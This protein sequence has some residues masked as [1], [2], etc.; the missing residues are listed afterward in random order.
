MQSEA[1]R[2]NH[3]YDFTLVSEAK[4]KLVENAH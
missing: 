1:L 4:F 3:L 2:V